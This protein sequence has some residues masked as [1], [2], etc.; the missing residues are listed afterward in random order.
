MGAKSFLGLPGERLVRGASHADSPANTL[1]RLVNDAAEVSALTAMLCRAF[2]AD[3]HINW[4]IRQ[5]ER[6]ETA[7]NALFRLLLT[8][9]GG[10]LHASA[11]RKS[12]ALWFPPGGGPDWR[13]Q[14]RFFL[15]YLNIAGPARALARGIDLKRMDQRHPARPHFYLQLLGVEP[16]CQRQ[17]HGGTL[18]ARL[19]ALASEADC[20]VYLETSSPGNVAFYCRHGFVGTAETVLSG[21][22]R[23]WS[24]LWQP[25]RP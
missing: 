15:R 8:D 17:G 21:G 18:L 7:M 24:L 13:A 23:L 25:G 6:R 19:L 22:L 14:S 1:C 12:A 2:Q 10:E 20:P 9:M 5:D 11:D 4:L 3:A 16:E